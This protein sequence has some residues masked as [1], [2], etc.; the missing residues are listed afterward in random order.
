MLLYHKYKNIF[1]QLFAQLMPC[2]LENERKHFTLNNMISF[3]FINTQAVPISILLC[4]SM[5]ILCIACCSFIQTGDS[6]SVPLGKEFY[7]IP[8][9]SVPPLFSKYDFIGYHFK[10]LK[11]IYFL[12]STSLGQ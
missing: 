12:V 9:M 11:F 8:R 6:F 1:L 5:W 2:K 3:S 7:Y 10:F 4:L